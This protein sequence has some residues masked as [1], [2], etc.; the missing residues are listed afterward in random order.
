MV[1]EQVYN[2]NGININ[3]LVA[4]KGK[5]TIVFIHGNSSWAQTWLP[6]L[7]DEA[8]TSAFKLVAI[9]LPGH[10][11]SDKSATYSLQGLAEFIN[12]LMPQLGVEEYILVAI[13]L[14]TAY[15]GEAAHLLNHC[16]GFFMLSSNLTSNEYNPGVYMVP[17]AQVMA[18]MSATAPGRLTCCRC[19]WQGRK[20]YSY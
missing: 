10:G 16:K 4:G 19:F 17:F 12:G 13:S 6:Q 3:T 15:A 8:L 20:S 5:K 18:L 14:G 11:K 2:I 9:D 1:A 7:A